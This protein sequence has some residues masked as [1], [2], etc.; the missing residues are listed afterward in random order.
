MRD[1]S[2]PF[3]AL[4]V[5]LSRAIPTARAFTVNLVAGIGHNDRIYAIG[6]LKKAEWPQGYLKSMDIFFPENNSWTSGPDMN[7]QRDGLG[8]ALWKVCSNLTEY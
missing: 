2:L 3:A 4:G 5:R 6:G 7:W 1:V 8:V